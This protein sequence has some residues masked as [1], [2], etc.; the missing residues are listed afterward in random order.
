MSIVMNQDI[1]TVEMGRRGRISFKCTALV[2]CITLQR[3]AH[4]Q[5]DVGNTYRAC[6]WVGKE[7]GVD[8]GGAGEKEGV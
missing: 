8:L 2:R 1:L 5:E 4:T 6:C 7:V 3:K